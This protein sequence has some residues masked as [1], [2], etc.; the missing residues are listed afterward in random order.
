MTYTRNGQE[1]LCELCKARHGLASFGYTEHPVPGQARLGRCLRHVR[2]S[3][4]K[5]GLA[6]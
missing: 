5:E 2:G 4:G 6:E 1:I 3:R